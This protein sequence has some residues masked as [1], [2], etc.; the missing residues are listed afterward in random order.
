[1]MNGPVPRKLVSTL[2]SS[3]NSSITS[4]GG[5]MVSAQPAT[6]NR[7]STNALAGCLNSTVYLSVASTECMVSKNV[8]PLNGD[9]SNTP[10][11]P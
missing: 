1:M 10:P 8:W 4:R 5:P 6:R 11:T 2:L 7:Y 3:P 9:F